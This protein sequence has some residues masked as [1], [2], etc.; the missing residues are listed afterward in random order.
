MAEEQKTDAGGAAEAEALDLGEFSS[1]LEKDFRV[2]DAESD[3]LQSLVANLAVAAKEKS[4]T[5]TISGNAVKSI[6]SLIA[7]ID[8]MLSKQMNE[9]LHAP[10]VR[11][12]EGT[13][14]GL[15]YLVNNTETDQKLKIRVMNMKKD[16]LADHL[17]D[18][19][20][21]MWD[22][23]A[24]FKKIYSDEYSMFGGEPFGAIV[25]AY[26]FSHK[27][28]DVG[29]LRNLSG[30]C[31]SAHAPFIAAAAPQLFRMES[32]QELPNPQDLEQIVSSPEYA[33]WQ[34]LRESE[35]ARYIGLTMPRVLGR[36]PYGAE[37]VPVKGFDFE[38]ELDGQHDHYVWMNAAF[39]M[40]VNINRSHKISGWG[41]Q[42]RGVESGGTVMN[43]PVHTFPTDDGSVAMKCPTE[44]AI[45]D[46]REAEL[47]KL[48]MMPIL[49]RKN[50]DVAAFIGAHSL[51]DDET[52]A[53][54][55]VDPDAQANERLSANLPYL[56]PVSRFAHYLKAIARDKVGSFKER[57]DMQV[58]L[59]EWINRYVLANPAMA[60]D[61][62]KARRPLAAAEV[63]VDSVEG[64]P[65]YYNAR[66]YLRPHYQLEGI[67]ASLRLVSEL[68][69]VKS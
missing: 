25:G 59:G 36:L 39:A 67:N 2:K 7:G 58:W 51:Q 38:E 69:S 30:I 6:K 17:E 11:E 31:A 26:E 48:G 66:F 32:W 62:A 27:P 34:S 63:Q 12:I 52:R 49:H 64:R 57:A 35:D 28:K 15:H 13:W 20:G 61:K 68:P 24:V 21:Q 56:F 19:E 55:L 44:I 40:G 3:K 65:G 60:D 37:T 18:Y 33:S 23:S 8:Q 41:T 54:K 46:R 42:I 43:L 22:Q 29:M 9:I 1:L 5:A 4:G 10:E 50:T 47:A 16:E 45:D 53:G 14:R